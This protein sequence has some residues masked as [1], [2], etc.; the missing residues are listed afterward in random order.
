MARLSTLLKSAAL[1]C[2]TTFSAASAFAD[3]Y[4]VYVYDYGY[5]PNTVYTAGVTS[6]RFVNKTNYTVTI[7]KEGTLSIVVNRLS[8]GGSTS[9]NLSDVSGRTLR[10]PYRVYNGQYYGSEKGELNFVSGSAPDTY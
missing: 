8:S 2:V 3:E 1:A 7:A 6:I 9:K 5:F 4:T 10:S